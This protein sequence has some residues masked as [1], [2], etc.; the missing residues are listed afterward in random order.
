MLLSNLTTD[1]ISLTFESE[2]IM[3]MSII[4]GSYQIHALFSSQFQNELAT[5]TL[6]LLNIL[7]VN[8]PQ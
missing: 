3:I 5:L 7:H 2:G 4:N 6:E 8:E 1:L